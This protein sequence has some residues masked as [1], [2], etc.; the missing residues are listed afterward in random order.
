MAVPKK[1]QSHGR[2][3]RRNKANSKVTLTGVTVCQSCGH[4]KKNH[5]RCIHCNAK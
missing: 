3:A 2:T 1:R 4:L 5:S